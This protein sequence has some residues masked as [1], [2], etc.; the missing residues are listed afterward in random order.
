VTRPPLDDTQRAEKLEAKRE[1]KKL[2]EDLL[3][4]AMQGEKTPAADHSADILLETQI[5]CNH[6]KSL[7]KFTGT[8]PEATQIFLARVNGITESCPTL[9]FTRV[10]GAIKPNIAAQVIKTIDAADCSTFRKFSDCLSKNYGCYSN[11][12]HRLEEWWLKPK[13]YGE[14][15][16]NHHCKITSELDPVIESFKAT[17]IKM[18]KDQGVED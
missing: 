7:P 10:L 16:T 2:Q 12:Y 1:L 11:V 5:L 13:P 15:M 4:L 14:S 18:K 17:I 8:N 9:V 3:N 6:L